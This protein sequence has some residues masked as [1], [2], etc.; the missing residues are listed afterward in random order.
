MLILLH[1][2]RARVQEWQI[3][4]EKGREDSA[5]RAESATDSCFFPGP[6]T[7][8]P[9]GQRLCM[10]RSETLTFQHFPLLRYD[11][12]TMGDNYP[13]ECIRRVWPHHEPEKASERVYF[14]VEICDQ[15]SGSRIS[16]MST[17]LLPN[18]FAFALSFVYF[19]SNSIVNINKN[20]FGAK[21]IDVIDGD[22]GEGDTL[23]GM[24]FLRIK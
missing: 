20:I 6:V 9:W 24:T 22:I 12:S 11:P 14:T 21:Q 5:L 13:S 2:S 3:Q 4:R 10:A 18:R 23:F 19:V 1:P 8:F 17:P 15:E 16:L 7:M